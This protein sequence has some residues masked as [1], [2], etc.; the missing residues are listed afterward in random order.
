MVLAIATFL[1][2]GI[3]SLVFAL[4]FEHTTFLDI[5][6]AIVPILFLGIGSSGIAY[7]LQ[8]LGQRKIS[9]VPAALIMSL[10]AVF[11]AIFAWVLLG[12]K[13]NIKEI[14]G[15]ILMMIGV[16]AVQIFDK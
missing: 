16:I 11:S 5:G 12:E 9:G 4:I 8:F 3:I 10:E 7:S 13:L 6:N 2:T 1:A 15:A 14:S